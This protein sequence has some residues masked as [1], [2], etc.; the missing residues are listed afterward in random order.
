LQLS[1]TTTFKLAIAFFHYSDL[2]FFPRPHTRRKQNTREIGVDEV[3]NKRFDGS[4]LEKRLPFQ[5]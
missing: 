4:E 5:F 1:L 3:R 2:T